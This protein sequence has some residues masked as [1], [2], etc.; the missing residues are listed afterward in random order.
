M[1][2]EIY[3]I[4]DEIKR[5]QERIEN[6]DMYNNYKEELS[7]YTHRLFSLKLALQRLEKDAYLS[8]E[9]SIVGEQIDLYIK[10]IHE[11]REKNPSELKYL[12]TLH[13]TKELIGSIDVRFNLLESEKYLGNIGANIDSNYRGKRYS[14]IAFI[15]LHDTML[16]HGLTKPIFTVN[17]NNNSS[18]HSV[19]TIGTTK[20]GSDIRNGNEYY[21]YEYD[22][23]KHQGK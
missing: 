22:I 13:G 6:I 17:I 5:V 7:F 4:Y 9:P 20:I 11:L 15:M 2:D 16:E 19:A 14:K 18:L 21:I 23:E 8:M 12:I 10:N 1:E 3:N